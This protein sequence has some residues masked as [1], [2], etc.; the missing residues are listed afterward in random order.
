MRVLLQK[1]QG[2]STEFHDEVEGDVVSVNPNA[3]LGLFLFS[4]G[5]EVL[6]Y[7]KDDTVKLFTGLDLD[8]QVGRNTL[9]FS[10]DCNY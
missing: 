9:S 7:L 3:G 5:R 1:Q 2:K 10:G 4:K 8:E 6:K